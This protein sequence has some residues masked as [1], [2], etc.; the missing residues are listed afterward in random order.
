[1]NWAVGGVGCQHDPHAPRDL[2]RRHRDRR[3][4]PRRRG[5]TRPVRPRHRVPRPGVGSRWPAELPG[6]H[7]LGA[8][9]AGPRR[10]ARPRRAGHGLGRL[11]RR[12]AGRRRRLGP[13]PPPAPTAWSAV[14]HSKGG[15]ALLLAEQRRPGTFAALCCY[16]PVVLP[17]A[18]RASRP[19]AEDNPLAAGRA[20]AGATLRVARQAAYDNSPGEAAAVD[21]RPRGAARLRRPRL[22]GPARRHRRAQVP[23]R[24][25][26]G[27]VFEMARAN[28]AFA[29]LG[30]VACPVTVAR[31]HR[32]LVRAG[33]LRPAPS[34][35]PCPT[36]GSWPSTDLGHFGPLERPAD[37][38]PASLGRAFADVRLIPTGRG[39]PGAVAP[40]A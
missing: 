19:P 16:E 37:G 28:D 10:L 1:M 6:Y 8:R 39:S 23:T 40:P 18:D 12:R 3:P 14:G 7:A 2:D 27:Q 17:A 13:G 35:R 20:A 5:P 11:R 25:R 32:G 31:G 15:A 29:H 38:R 22:R 34:S 9:P 30:E 21:P 4:R 33:G 36:A 24:G 26:G